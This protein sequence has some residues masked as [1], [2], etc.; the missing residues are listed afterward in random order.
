MER[1]PTFKA[2]SGGG[3]AVTTALAKTWVRQ[4]DTAD[5]TLVASLCVAAQAAV[6]AYTNRFLVSGVWDMFL[7][8]YP[9]YGRDPRMVSDLKRNRGISDLILIPKCPV[10][11]VSAV[12]TTND[13][14]AESTQSSTTYLVDTDAEPA[15]IILLEGESWGEMRHQK[16][17]RIRFTAG[18]AAAAI[19]PDALQ[20]AI[21]MTVGAWYDDREA[22]GKGELPPA[23][24]LAAN[25]YRVIWL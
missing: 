13:A 2:I 21:K 14:A 17:M 25:P 10:T 4:D 9:Y 22:M 19:V 23:A 6:E 8:N 5:D 20:L 3:Q 1:V 12:Y 18:Y 7:D 24:K 16:S 15:R 11:A